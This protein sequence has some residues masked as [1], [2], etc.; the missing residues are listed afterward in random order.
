MHK[1][2]FFI[3][4]IIIL[5]GFLS[6]IYAEELLV[7]YEF[8]NGSKQPS[9]KHA[10]LFAGNEFGVYNT[11]AVSLEMVLEAGK[12]YL[13]VRNNATAV[14]S[15]RYGYISLASEQGYEVSITRVEVVSKK[16]NSNTQN[17][18]SYLYGALSNL[19]LLTN[20]IYS[21]SNAGY[22]IPENW[23]RK[24]FQPSAGVQVLAD[25]VYFSFTS[26]QVASSS[27][28]SDWQVDELVFYGNVT[29]GPDDV[30][31]EVDVTID[32]SKPGHVIS[33]L[34]NG[35]HFVY[36]NEADNIY[37]DE[38]IADW[39]REVKTGIIRWPGG[40]AVMSYHWDNLTGDNFGPDRWDTEN[41]VEKNIPASN[42]MDLDE[43]I[44]WCRKVNALPMVGV[45]ILSGK[46]FRT[47]ADGLAEAKR[48]IQYCVDNNY[49]VKHWYIG[50]EGYAKGFAPQIYANYIDMYAAEL[51]KVD[52]DIIIIGDWKFGPEDKNRYQ[53]ML[54]VVQNSVHLDVMEIHEKWGNDWGIV[55]GT[56]LE[57]WKNEFPIYNGKMDYYS[58]KFHEDVA[59]M[60]K[61]TKLGFN[62]WG[63]GGMVNGNEYH[64]AL[65]A[66]D[67]MTQMFKNDVY[68]AC[69]WNLNISS[70]DGGKSRIFTTNNQQ[71]S[72]FNPVAHVFKQYAPVLGN[73]YLEVISSD[74]QVYGIASI[75]PAQDT[76]QLLLLN[77]SAQKSN[78]RLTVNGF[79]ASEQVWIDSF[80]QL[81]KY[82]N[83]EHVS[84]SLTFLLP[85]YSF[86]GLQ[87]ISKTTATRTLNQ[88]DHQFSVYTKD[89]KM[90]IRICDDE[91]FNKLTLYNARGELIRTVHRSEINSG[92]SVDDFEKGVY[93]LIASGLHKRY[94]KKI[95]L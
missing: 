65:L 32:V 21:G 46:L 19:P 37:K 61:N 20:M 92:L 41:Y 2:H 17:A 52:P 82:V 95:I 79:S 78:L 13:S 80:D 11:T 62:E 68:S 38:R 36:G 50:N 43:Y 12:D 16:G 90:F 53:A 45:N 66:A 60:G 18:R 1:K 55:S 25:T 75:S 6:T 49:N 64:Y 3:I 26:T 47:D 40:T 4:I 69:Y 73:H 87:L 86:T 63:L 5:S 91:K 22:T 35:S 58:K 39:M 23:E 67:L 94:V 89:K 83:T 88:A 51:K 14:D 44:A 15:K 27:I 8:T 77:K 24:S 28:S 72:A 57:D 93:V 30:P 74:R 7:K 33:P 29:G 56:T 9:F 81:G 85:A 10:G 54:S 59:A 42:Y 71:F 76:L 48:L 70:G 34:M 31:N 84:D